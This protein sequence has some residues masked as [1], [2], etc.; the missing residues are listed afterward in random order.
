MYSGG[1][2]DCALDLEVKFLDRGFLPA[3]ANQ[4]LFEYKEIDNNLIT[5]K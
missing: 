2:L 1:T 3:M 4:T 5:S